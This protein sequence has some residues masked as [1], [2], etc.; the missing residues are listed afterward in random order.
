VTDLEQFGDGG[1]DYGHGLGE[2]RNWLYDGGWGLRDREGPGPVLLMIKLSGS[3]L[4]FALASN[5]TCYLSPAAV[6][7]AV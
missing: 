2:A 6:L 1:R 7:R 5:L 3:A 4:V